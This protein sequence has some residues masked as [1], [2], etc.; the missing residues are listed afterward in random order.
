MDTQLQNVQKQIIQ[1]AQ[2][3]EILDDYYIDEAQVIDEDE[4]ND[5][6]R[7]AEG[8][9]GLA[10]GDDDTRALT[11]NGKGKKKKKK[12]LLQRVKNAFTKKPK[13]TPEAG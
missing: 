8:K 2:I 12:T 4:H 6:G 1:N 3:Q 5:E 11:E 7:E 10:E 13:K 9:D